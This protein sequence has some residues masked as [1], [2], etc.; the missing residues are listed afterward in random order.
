MTHAEGTEGTSPMAQMRSAAAPAETLAPMEFSF[1]V[2]PHTSRLHPFR[3]QQPLGLSLREDDGEADVVHHGRLSLSELRTLVKQAKDFQAAWRGLT[4]LQQRLARGAAHRPEALSPENFKPAH[5]LAGSRSRFILRRH[6]STDADEAGAECLPRCDVS[7][8]YRHGRLGGRTLSFLQPVGT[9]RLTGVATTSPPTRLCMECLAPLAPLPGQEMSVLKESARGPLG[10]KILYCARGSESDLFCSGPCRARFFGKRNGASLR[11]QLFELE[12]GVCQRCGLDCHSLWQSLQNIAPAQ[13]LVKLR[14]LADDLGSSRSTA[15][16]ASTDLKEASRLRALTS[17]LQTKGASCEGKEERQEGQE[18][19]D[20]GMAAKAAKAKKAKKAKKAEPEPSSPPP[21]SPQRSGNLTEGFLWQ[22]D[23]V[24]PVWRGGGV[25]GLENL[26]TLCAAC[27][28][29]KTKQEAQ[30]RAEARRAQRQP[31][32][33]PAGRLAAKAKWALRAADAKEIDL[34]DVDDEESAMSAGLHGREFPFLRSFEVVHFKVRIFAKAG[35]TEP[36]DASSTRWIER[37]QR[38]T[39]F[40]AYVKDPLAWQRTG[41]YK[42]LVFAWD[43]RQQKYEGWEAS[44]LHTRF[45]T[46]EE[47]S[48]GVKLLND[49][50]RREELLTSWTDDELPSL[51]PL[52]S[53]GGST[54]T[55][56]PRLDS[57]DRDSVFTPRLTGYKPYG[58][59]EHLGGKKSP[60]SRAKGAPYARKVTAKATEAA[61]VPPGRGHRRGARAH[62]RVADSGLGLR[63]LL[64]GLSCQP[65][66]PYAQ[67]TALDVVQPANPEFDVGLFDGRTLPLPDKSMDCALFSFVLHH[68]RHFELQ[69]ALLM[70]AA[71]VSRSWVVIC[72]D[73]PE[74]TIH[75]KGTRG[76]DHLGQFH[77]A[78]EWRKMFSKIGFNLLH[79]GPIWEG[80][81]KGPSPYF[82]KRCYFILQVPAGLCPQPSPGLVGLSGC[83]AL[84]TRGEAGA[85]HSSLSDDERRGLLEAA[86]EQDP[87]GAE[88]IG[89]IKE[90]W[91]KSTGPL[92]NEEHED[93]PQEEFCAFSQMS[94]PRRLEQNLQL[95]GIL[96]PSPIQRAAIPVALTGQDLVGIAATGSGKTLAYLLPLLLRALSAGLPEGAFGLVLLPTRELALQVAACADALLGSSQD[97]DAAQT[98]DVESHDEA[99]SR[100]SVVSIWGG[101]PR[102]E[103]QHQLQHG[104]KW[105]HRQLPGHAWVIAATPGRLLDLICSEVDEGR[106][107]LHGVRV[108]VLDEGDRMLE[109]GLGDQLDAVARHT[110]LLRQTL[111]FSATWCEG[112]V[113]LQASC[114]CR[115]SPVMVQVGSGDSSDQLTTSLANRNILQM[116]EVFDQEE[117][118]EERETR[119]LSRLL[120]LLRLELQVGGDSEEKERPLFKALV[121][122]MTK[123][124]A[125]CL[126]EKLNEAS[127]EAVAIHGNKTQDERLF[128]LDL[129]AN[130]KP[131]GPR[132]L[133]ATDVLG[134]GIDLPNVTHVFVFDMPGCIED[135]IHRIGRTARGLD[136]QGKAITFFEFAPCVPQ[137]AKEL[138]V[139][140]D[141]CAQEIPAELQQI[142]EDVSSGR[143]LQSKKQ[144]TREQGNAHGD[145]Q[146][147]SP[148]DLATPEEL[149]EWNAGG[150]RSWMF[151][152]ANLNNGKASQDS[153]WLVFKKAGVLHT[154]RGSGSWQLEEEQMLVRFGAFVLRLTLHK[155]WNGKKHLN[156]CTEDLE[157]SGKSLSGWVQKSKSYK[158]HDAGADPPNGE[159]CPP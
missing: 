69:R 51:P 92:S 49:A 95:Q 28:G 87:A 93:V 139:H 31:R 105:P 86:L 10:E 71:R 63:G 41:L 13:R 157:A 141:E 144:R 100:V 111:F 113:G 104:R 131:S 121:F 117:S 102:W 19:S 11:H 76:H 32:L 97:K 142:A 29:Q 7:V 103:Q 119:K 99:L 54:G 56:L 40:C 14:R 150:Y 48:A 55:R 30:E 72:E 132:I 64:P 73:T 67:A 47:V 143:R 4:P 112:K 70:E 58:T 84:P 154:D 159:E 52:E 88:I 5:A 128:N 44:G 43:R 101:A 155:K 22:A 125:D 21:S 114:L 20:E 16:T 90:R 36:A 68:C 8:E 3:N 110:A 1:E 127:C 140:L 45:F 39:V 158:F 120:E 106:R 25:C 156:F 17:H 27:H 98:L 124:F 53:C 82:C 80:P 146:S 129:F 60:L 116:V 37:F 75:W 12:R 81:R 65:L 123:K 91:F 138:M 24:V 26:Q 130:S 2:S 122:C 151:E 50:G 62:G 134:R 96:K 35:V 78:S 118:E 109:E 85:A 9:G 149:G 77:P 135:Y 61:D 133:V 108:L 89:N 66:D 23:H 6:S 153:G 94:L 59:L 33:W 137:L 74:E 38:G 115:Q 126:V 79:Q 147:T 57:R 83:C 15:S 18:G 107:P 34:E 145:Q 136:G 46:Q 42:Y 148:A 152:N